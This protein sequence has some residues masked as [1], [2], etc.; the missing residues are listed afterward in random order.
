M[1]NK[2]MNS[3][4]TIRNDLVEHIWLFAG[5]RLVDRTT[6]VQLRNDLRFRVTHKKIYD[7][8]E[9]SSFQ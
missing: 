1:E 2:R 6:H 7:T 8:Q 3:Y 4:P 9:N 5:K